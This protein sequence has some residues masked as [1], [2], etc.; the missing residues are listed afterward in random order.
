MIVLAPV[1][2]ADEET[3]IL[4]ALSK[5][6]SNLG[7]LSLEPRLTVSVAGK[8]YLIVQRP[9][10]M[11]AG[12]GVTGGVVWSSTPL[13]LELLSKLQGRQLRVNSSETT[14]SQSCLSFDL[15][16]S[17][18][19][20]LGSGSHG[21]AALVLAQYAK[22]FI[23]SDH[24]P[25]LLRQ[26]SKNCCTREARTTR[27]SKDDSDQDIRLEAQRRDNIRVLELNWEDD[28][29]T[30][31]RPSIASVLTEESRS[32]GEGERLHGLDL[33]LCLDC[34]YSS[35]LLVHLVTTI[36]QLLKLY[37]GCKAVLGQQLRDETVHL[38]FVEQL[39]S[40]G[41]QVFRL[42]DEDAECSSEMQALD[43][44]AVY[45]VTLP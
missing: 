31:I 21:L 43:G 33:I 24:D 27:R 23:A 40:H 18:I 4:Y 17:V 6:P 10:Y 44:Y 13:I 29:D 37:P 2:D 25:E 35:Y 22:L 11:L 41:L 19:L 38:E 28:F 39:L 3:S 20:E 30:H 42:E 8:D 9:E 14:T 7:Y 16:A 5:P 32:V 34:V 26:L 12:K 45:V 15:N 1:Y 36:A